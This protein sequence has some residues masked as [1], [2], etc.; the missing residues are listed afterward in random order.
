ML[1]EFVHSF[2]EVGIGSMLMFEVVVPSLGDCSQ[3]FLSLIFWDFFP[4]VSDESV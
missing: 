1:H 4:D 2:L 3:N